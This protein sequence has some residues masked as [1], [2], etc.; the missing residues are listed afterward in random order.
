MIYYIKD[1][2]FERYVFLVYAY[3]KIHKLLHRSNNTNKGIIKRKDIY[4]NAG[5]LKVSYDRQ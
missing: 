2:K 3:S 5:S 1:F 4:F